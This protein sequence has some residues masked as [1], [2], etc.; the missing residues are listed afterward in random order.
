EGSYVASM[1]A[2][3]PADPP[4]EGDE[5]CLGGNWSGI[6]RCDKGL[7][8]PGLPANE[9]NRYQR[10]GLHASQLVLGLG[11]WVP[12]GTSDLPCGGPGITSLGL[13]VFA[14]RMTLRD[15]TPPTFEN[16]DLASQFGAAPVRGVTD[17][18]V[19]AADQG[20]GLSETA[21]VVDGNELP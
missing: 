9:A 2:W 12:G 17:V 15:D 4:S 21:L 14:S 1:G 16:D 7:G 19:T 11:C 6:A 18:V 8:I 5:R 20:A 13:V 10:Q 3:P